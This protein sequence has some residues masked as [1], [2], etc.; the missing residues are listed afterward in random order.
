[1]TG[2][3]D[4]VTGQNRLYCPEQSNTR[5][6]ASTTFDELLAWLIE[7]LNGQS[8]VYVQHDNGPLE[9]ASAIALAFSQFMV[10]SGVVKVA[11][12]SYFERCVFL[13]SF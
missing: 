13:I 8:V 9:K 12:T 11:V 5:K 2:I 1:M 4:Y 7:S 10:D 3:A 6:D